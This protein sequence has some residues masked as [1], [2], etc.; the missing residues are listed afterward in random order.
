MIPE[1]SDIGLETRHLTPEGK[2]KRRRVGE[3]GKDPNRMWAY[4]QVVANEVRLKS[5]PPESD[6]IERLKGKRDERKNY[7]DK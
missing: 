6:F 5:T 7:T 1:N 4:E 3:A 2:K